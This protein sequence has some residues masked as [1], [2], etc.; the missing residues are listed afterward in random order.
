MS[1]LFNDGVAVV[2]FVVILGI[3]TGG[4]QATVGS[5]S[6]LFLEEAVGGSLFGLVI[7]GLLIGNHGRMFA[8]SDITRQ[9]ADDSRHL[10]DEVL[11]TALFLRVKPE[12]KFLP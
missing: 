11:N 9:H 10:I 5:I 8:M 6:L 4:G 7:A 2:V 3:A 12:M 1:P